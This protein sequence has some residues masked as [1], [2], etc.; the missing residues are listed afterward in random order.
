VILGAFLFI[1]SVLSPTIGWIKPAAASDTGVTGRVSCDDKGNVGL[2]MDIRG[3]IDTSTLAGVR[4]LFDQYHEAQTSTGSDKCE[5]TRGND[6]SA[7]G[8]HF[9]ISS[10]GGYLVAAMAIGRIFRKENAW[11][12]VNGPC[13]SSCVFILA[14]AVDR[15]I[16]K[17]GYVGIH[18]PYLGTSTQNLDQVREAYRRVLKDMRAYLREMDVSDRLA[19]DMLAIEPEDVRILTNSEL[20]KYR[21][22]GPVPA[23][24]QRVAIEREANDVQKANQLGIDRLEYTRRKALARSCIYTAAGE[25]EISQSAFFSCKERILKTGRRN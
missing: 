9:E 3:K 11:L 25:V 7:L 2:T 5:R 17:G 8:T 20:K 12:M 13:V 10:R 14:G 21:L 1:A 16:G 15:Q 6:L 18:R 4:Q 24:R 19:D 22:E 23:E